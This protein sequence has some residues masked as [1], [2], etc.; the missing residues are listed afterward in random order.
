MKIGKTEKHINDIIERGSGVFMGL[1]DPDP[2]KH[3]TESAVNL[4]KDLNRGG[5]DVI[6]LGGS[7][8][9]QGSFLDN[10]AKQIKENVNV[11]LHLFPGNIGNV[12]RYADS[13]Y[14]MSLLNSKNPYWIAGAPILGA[15][16]I[17]KYN[18][19]PI[20]AAYLVFEPGETVGWVGE[21]RLI[22]KKKPDV[23]VMYSLAAQYMGMR[24]AI[25]ESGSGSPDPVPE[26]IVS[27]VRK[28]VDINIVIAGGVKT[29]AQ[30]R[31]LIRAGANCIHVGT[32][33]ENAKDPVER[34]RMF[35][36][37]IH[38]KS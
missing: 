9:A 31:D 17:K 20:P 7:I 30:A 12:T 29:P 19:E 13:I 38:Q 28:S 36:R 26:E 14:F 24:F 25:L 3:T 33:I 1:I 15:P 23:A 35:A 32:K 37:A 11:P 5:A 8:G 21:S 2:L 16:I 18:I 10:V 27:A 4:A 6:M 22:P 34:I